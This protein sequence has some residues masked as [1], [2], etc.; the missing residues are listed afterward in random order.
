MKH[1]IKY[2]FLSFLNFLTFEIKQSSNILDLQNNQSKIFDTE[3]NKNLDGYN[4]PRDQYF[5]DLFSISS[6]FLSLVF[7]SKFEN[8]NEKLKNKQNKFIEAIEPFL[9]EKKLN[10]WCES[11]KIKTTENLKILSQKVFIQVEILQKSFK[12]DEYDNCLIEIFDLLN[13]LYLILEFK[14]TED[15]NELIEKMSNLIQLCCKWASL[16]DLESF[17]KD[18]KLLIEKSIEL[19]LFAKLF[20]FEFEYVDSTVAIIRACSFI[21][22]LGKMYLI[23]S[24]EDSFNKMNSIVEAVET[25]FKKIQE[26]FSGQFSNNL[27]ISLSQSITNDKILEF[28]SKY[29]I[30]ISNLSNSILKYKTI[31]NFDPTISNFLTQIVNF[32]QIIKLQAI[33]EQI[34]DFTESEFQI[35]RTFQLICIH[36]LNFVKKEDQV[37]ELI[38]NTL[39][40]SLQCAIEMNLECS[41]KLFTHPVVTF[42]VNI[43]SLN[44]LLATIWYSTLNF[45]DL[46]KTTTS[47]NTFALDMTTPNV[48]IINTKICTILNYNKIEKIPQPNVGKNSSLLNKIDNIPTDAPTPWTLI[49]S[50]EINENNLPV[51][52]PQLPPKI[53]KF[54]SNSSEDY[55]SWMIARYQREC[56]ENALIVYKRKLKIAQNLFEK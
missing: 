48:N 34:D 50:D 25:K 15:L 27:Q 37:Y 22:D 21:T 19:V 18:S 45:C 9:N 17:E 33:N 46:F 16:N 4:D 31:E 32:F 51:G 8:D 55:K 43:L 10:I 7:E 49:P 13:E 11:R 53:G 35:V 23:H 47:D 5:I 44:R 42:E 2:L 26:N 1:L 56:A 40:V 6:A 3:I 29:E 28:N 30:N 12:N 20:N 52:Y 24:N 39:F 41:R 54:K 36:F 14:S 38:M